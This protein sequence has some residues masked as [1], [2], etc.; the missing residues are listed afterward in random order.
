MKHVIRLNK[1]LNV[2][3]KLAIIQGNTVLKLVVLGVEHAPQGVKNTYW[4]GICLK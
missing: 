4:V 1:V 3:N 2:G